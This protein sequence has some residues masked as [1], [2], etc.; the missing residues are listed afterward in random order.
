MIIHERLSRLLR[1]RGVF[2]EEPELV[3]RALREYA[4]G[5]ADLADYL[6]LG[7]ARAPG[8]GTLVTFDKK[9]AREADV[10]LL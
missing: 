6:I 9:L 5:K 3:Q 7:W 1:T 4:R 8:G 10:S 2:V